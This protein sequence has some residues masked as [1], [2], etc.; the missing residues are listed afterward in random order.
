MSAPTTDARP[1]GP[2]ASQRLRR[3]R[4]PA[5]IVGLVLLAGLVVALVG[6]A[7][8]QGELLP[9]SPGPQGS[10]ALTTLLGRQG[11]EV[12]T[13]TD[14]DTPAAGA[15]RTVL[16]TF[17]ARL[18]TR[19]RDALARSAA[20]VIL[21]R[22]DERTL[23]ALAPGVV[24]APTELPE[25]TEPA[26]TV[27]AAVLAGPV[28]LTGGAY[29]APPGAERCYPTGEA[30]AASLVRLP[31]A[32]RTITVLGDATPLTNDALDE[33]G[34][35]ALSLDLL[36]A[37]PRLLWYVPV[38]PPAEAGQER[39]VSDLLPAGWLWG[40]VQLLVAGLAVALWRGRRLGP[41]VPENLPVVVPAGET[42]RGRARLYRRAGARDR[43]AAAL[44]AEA[45]RDLTARLGLPRA[46]PVPAVAEA[47]GARIRRHPGEVAALL[48]GPAPPDDPALV[49]LAAELDRLVGEVHGA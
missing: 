41:L 13:V 45:L 7:P 18:S 42:V 25:P 5:L 14:L 29:A 32:G 20:D 47:V 3:A 23:T 37:H 26:C 49:A 36:G 30:G 27:R 35:A 1:L 19:Q 40:P 21:L 8:S 31:V 9:D 28:D 2:S 39:S 11:V 16:V 44:R 34:N 10:R 48:G 33:R 6:A 15:G 4:G 38:P 17:P 43:A 22:P 12:E 46:A 24:S